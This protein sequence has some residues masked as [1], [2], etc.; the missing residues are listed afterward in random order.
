MARSPLFSHISESLDGLTTIRYNIFAAIFLIF[1]SAYGKLNE[2][3]NEH[4]RRLD[5]HTRASFSYISSARWLGFRLDV[6]V[7]VLLAAS[8]FGAVIALNYKIG[9]DPAA[10][11]AGVMY[12]T[13]V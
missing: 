11:S 8:T 4:K 7:V 1:N 12:V 6:I 9:G 5:A 13:T 10:L 2:F 3:K